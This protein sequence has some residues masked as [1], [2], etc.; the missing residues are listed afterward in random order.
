MN[1]TS[2]TESIKYF[3]WCGACGT[4]DIDVLFIRV[5]DARVRQRIYIVAR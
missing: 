1:T 5:V 2:V 3:S 4:Y